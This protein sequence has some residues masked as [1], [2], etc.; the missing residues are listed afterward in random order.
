L[1][2]IEIIKSPVSTLIPFFI[3]PPIL[4]LGVMGC[5]FELLDGLGVNVRKD[6]KVKVWLYTSLL[7]YLL[8]FLIQAFGVVRY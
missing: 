2:F 6:R 3:I 1:D 7:L 8:A 4:G 5:L